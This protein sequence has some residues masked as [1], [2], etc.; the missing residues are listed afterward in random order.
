MI[1]GAYIEKF[2]VVANTGNV[3][4]NYDV[5]LSELINTFVDKNDLIY[6]L[7]MVSGSLEQYRN[8][9]DSVFDNITPVVIDAVVPSE[10]GEQ[11]KIISNRHI[12]VNEAQGFIFRM[13][14]KDDGT[15]QDDN[16]GRGFSAKISVN[17]YKEAEQIA[18]LE[19]G[20]SFNNHIKS[21]DY[22]YFQYMIM[23]E[24]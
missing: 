2:F 12:G 10:G 3:E 15:N 8:K 21:L 13:T 16:K 6:S 22:L 14:F 11:A 19:A 17:E 18:L 7:Y 1:P 24:H 20:P 9:D 5:Y 4:T 23:N